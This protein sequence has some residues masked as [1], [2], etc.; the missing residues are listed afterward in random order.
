MIG[1]NGKGLVI[2]ERDRILLRELSVMRVIDRE[3]AKVAGRFGSTTRVNTRLLALTRH[4]FLRRYFLGTSAGG[5][6]A[7]YALSRKGAQLI[8]VPLRGPQRPKDETRP[9]DFFVEHQLAVNAVYCALKFGTLP[10]GVTFHRFLSFSQPITPAIRL[11]P[12]GYVE[13]ITPS[14]TFAAFLEVDLGHERGPIWEKKCEKYLQFAVRNADERAAIHRPFRVL[15]I[16]PT[17]RRLQS[18]RR[19]VARIT[20]KVFWFGSQEYINREGLFGSVWLRPTGE[21]RLSLIK[22]TP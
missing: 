14:G 21:E 1:N 4:Q 17:E 19:M 18:I 8:G 22:E 2:Q 9:V 10:D 15:V 7:L 16:L 11:I 12:D 13:L 6:K 20:P 5:T 3:Q